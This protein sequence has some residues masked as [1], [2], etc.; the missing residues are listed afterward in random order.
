MSRVT[1]TDRLAPDSSEVDGAVGYADLGGLIS[2]MTGDEKQS[3]SAN[4]TLDVLWVLYD[5]VFEIDPQDPDAD[6]RDRFLLSK[7]HCPMAYYAVLAA[8]GFFDKE[9]L[10]TT[11]RTGWTLQ[12]FAIKSPPGSRTVLL[13]GTVALRS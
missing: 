5:R 4:S 6:D 13:R 8:K 10:R 11:R 2:L 7:G 3:T 12:A 1:P 9:V